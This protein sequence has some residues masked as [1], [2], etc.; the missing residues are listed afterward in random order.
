MD[1]ELVTAVEFF[2]ELLRTELL[3]LGTLLWWLGPGVVSRFSIAPV[4]DELD[5][6]AVTGFG[7]LLIWFSELLVAVAR[8]ELVLIEK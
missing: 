3:L 4:R 6:L 8:A 7:W 1:I 5:P 2:D